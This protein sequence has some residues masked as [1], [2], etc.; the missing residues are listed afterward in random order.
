MSIF[1]RN[2]IITTGIT[3]V[4]CGTIYYYF[5]SRLR[6]LEMALA[7]QNQI[8]S[9]FI[10]NVQNEFRMSSRGP[11]MEMAS[12]EAISAVAQMQPDKIVISDNECDS[13]DESVSDDDESV[14][15]DDESVSDNDESVSDNNQHKIV[16]CDL[17]KTNNSNVKQSDDIKVIELSTYTQSEEYTVDDSDDGSYSSSDSDED[18]LEIQVVEV[19]EPIAAVAEVAVAEVAVAEVAVAEVAIVEEAPVSNVNVLQLKDE[20]IDVLRKLV[21]DKGL[22]KK[23]EAKK[24]KKNELL[25]IL[26]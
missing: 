4:I 26:L 5:N 19:V 1:D 20:K 2:F 25:A 21:V 10:S 23:E 15:D 3:A 7:K 16:I 24:L 13:D 6:E 12:S 11:S 9:S 22:A 17:A 14:S 8:L 18:E